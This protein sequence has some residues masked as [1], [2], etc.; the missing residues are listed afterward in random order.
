[1]WLVQTDLF[2]MSKLTLDFEDL[3]WGKKNVKYLNDFF[4]MNTR[5]F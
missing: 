4:V 5:K 3:A 2:C 1:M